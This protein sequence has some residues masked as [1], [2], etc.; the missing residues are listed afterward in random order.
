M[1]IFRICVPRFNAN[2]KTQLDFKRLRLDKPWRGNVQQLF[3]WWFNLTH[4]AKRL[5]QIQ[6]KTV[7]SV[8]SNI[9]PHDLTKY[10]TRL[11]CNQTVCHFSFTTL[12]LQGVHFYLKTS[13]KMTPHAHAHIYAWQEEYVHKCQGL[14]SGWRKRNSNLSNYLICKPDKYWS[15]LALCGAVNWKSE[16]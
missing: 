7:R 11:I 3:K 14:Y 9:S 10:L 16:F 15:W 8:E 2:T 5:F 1:H 12:N 13:D 6:S 4:W